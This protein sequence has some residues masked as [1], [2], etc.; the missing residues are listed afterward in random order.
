[1]V[2]VLVDLLRVP[3]LGQ[4]ATENALAAHPDHLGRETSLRGTLALTEAHVPALPLGGVLAVHAG[5]GVDRDRL[6][7]HVTILHELADVL[8]GVRHRDLVDLI[9]VKPDLAT[10]ALEHGRGQALLETKR[11]HLH[12]RRHPQPDCAGFERGTRP[13]YATA[14][15]G[16]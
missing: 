5:A 12:G 2:E 4:E 7:D 13:C 11:H 16:R 3:V 15:C 6:A 1:M 10:P 9:R 8:A 14:A